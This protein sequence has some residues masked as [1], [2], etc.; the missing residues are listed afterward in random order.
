MLPDLLLQHPNTGREVDGCRF[1]VAVAEHFLEAEQ[2][3]AAFEHEG[4][5]SGRS[6]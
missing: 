5:E 1:D 2:V 6:L 4:G 3:A